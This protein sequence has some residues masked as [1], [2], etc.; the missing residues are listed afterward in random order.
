RSKITQGKDEQ[1]R[2]IDSI[3]FI[4]KHWDESIK[5][6]DI[7]DGRTTQLRHD[8]D[9]LVFTPVNE[10]YPL[11][12]SF[13]LLLKWKPPQLNTVDFVI[14]EV[15]QIPV[16]FPSGFTENDLP[17]FFQY[18]PHLIDQLGIDRNKP[19]DDQL[20]QQLLQKQF[21]LALFG[22]Y[23]SVQG[24]S[25]FNC[26]VDVQQKVRANTFKGFNP[27]QQQSQ[28]KSVIQSTMDIDKSLQ[29]NEQTQQVHA[30]HPSYGDDQDDN[31][32]PFINGS[33]VECRYD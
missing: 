31:S 3:R 24:M 6:K 22:M 29:S 28:Q 2:P 12:R 13:D 33:V 5:L 16:L 21:V 27:S 11:G 8:C 19:I 26:F 17:I 4:M 18:F 14:Q 15:V 7:W 9:G 1:Q 23:I 30:Q 25:K 10:G 20:L 32:L